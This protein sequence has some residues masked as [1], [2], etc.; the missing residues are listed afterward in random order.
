MSSVRP[1][2]RSGI[3]SATASVPAWRMPAVILASIH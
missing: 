1:M 3:W 2:R